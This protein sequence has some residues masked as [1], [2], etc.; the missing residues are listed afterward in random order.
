[1]QTE[2][3]KI[4]LITGASSGIGEATARHVA[5]LGHT[6]VLGAR[7]T[8]RLEALAQEIRESGGTVETRK[9]DVTNLEDTQAFADFAIKKFGRVDVIINNAGV[10]PL[11]PLHELKV[12]E[13][14]QM[15][16]VN[17]RGVLH[18]IAAVLPHLQTRK[19][20]HVINVSSIGGFQVWPTCAVYSGTKFA[21]RAISEGLRLENKEVRVTIISPG[22]VESEL[23][24]TISDP[25][26][27]EMIEDFRAVA[28]TPDAIARGI[29]YAIEQPA[30]VDVNEI[31]IRP[32]AGAQ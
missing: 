25:A 2:S 3:P 29:A 17:I 15:I 6:V 13:W 9:L 11:S 7:R 18:G 14:N 12:A 5:A 32:T 4:I 1:M 21:V 19:A 16:D 22:V 10:M 23:A 20:G 24:H 27:R 30:D 8:E 26:T 31:I 28:L